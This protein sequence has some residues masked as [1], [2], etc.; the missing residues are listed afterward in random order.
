MTVYPETGPREVHMAKV[1]THMTM[2]L[3]GYIADPKDG[4]GELFGWYSA[5]DLTGHL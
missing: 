2:L 3:D 4:T 5:A 1:Y